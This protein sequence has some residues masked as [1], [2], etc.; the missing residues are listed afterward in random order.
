V[1]SA[2]PRPSS[3]RIEAN[4]DAKRKE[5]GVGEG[6]KDIPGVTTP[7]LVAFGEHGIKSVIDLADCATDDLEGWNE[8]KDGKTIRHAGILERFRVSRKDCEAIIINAR[9]KAGWIK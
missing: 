4:S 1:P 3:E 6:L 5:L 7:M 8:T 2:E 9:I